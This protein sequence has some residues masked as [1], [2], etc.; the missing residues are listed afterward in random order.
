MALADGTEFV[1][2]VEHCVRVREGRDPHFEAAEEV[3][4]PRDAAL[5][6]ALALALGDG[7]ALLVEAPLKAQGA[8]EMGDEEVVTGTFYEKHRIGDSG[9]IAARCCARGSPLLTLVQA[10]LPAEVGHVLPYRH[11]CLALAP[12][13]SCRDTRCPVVRR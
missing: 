10:A 4:V 8:R 12:T 11:H 7:R 13:A 2:L 5:A 6:L 1:E 3:A 9:S